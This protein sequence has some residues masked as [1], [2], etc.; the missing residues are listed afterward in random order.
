M[1]RNQYSDLMK[2][3]LFLFVQLFFPEGIIFYLQWSIDG[4]YFVNYGS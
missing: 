3:T 4:F 1:I 2:G